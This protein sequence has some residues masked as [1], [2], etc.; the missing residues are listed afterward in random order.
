MT[1]P[2]FTRQMAISEWE[3]L[4]PTE[5]AC[6]TYLTDRRWPNGVICPRCGDESVHPVSTRPFHW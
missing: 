1:R 2:Q 6:K 5:E 4:F 3:R